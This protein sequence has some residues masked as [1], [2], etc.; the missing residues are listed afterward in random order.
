MRDG[1]GLPPSI[2]GPTS[3]KT[4]LRLTLYHFI[5]AFRYIINN[6]SCMVVAV[7]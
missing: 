4:I 5:D 3:V 6:S 2:I 7:F 1:R